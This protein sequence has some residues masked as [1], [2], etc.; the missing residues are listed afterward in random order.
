MIPAFAGTS[1]LIQGDKSLS[2][3]QVT[4][5]RGQVTHFYEIGGGGNTLTAT[6]MFFRL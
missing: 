5:L 6:L 2:R 4:R 3:G 1:P